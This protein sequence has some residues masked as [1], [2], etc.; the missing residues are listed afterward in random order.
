MD[1]LFLKMFTKSLKVIPMG[2]D[3]SAIFDEVE[4]VLKK[5]MD[6]GREVSVMKKYRE[7]VNDSYFYVPEVYEEY[8]LEESQETLNSLFK[9]FGPAKIK[10]VLD[11]SSNKVMLE[12]RISLHFSL[13]SF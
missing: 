8:S 13:I 3:A 2:V 11:Q 1:M 5:E 7:L 4:R 10:T 12:S 6:Y 9:E